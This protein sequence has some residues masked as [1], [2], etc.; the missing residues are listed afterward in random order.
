VPVER[1]T[2]Y[3]ER[4]RIAPEE[5]P[6]GPQLGPRADGTPLLQATTDTKREPSTAD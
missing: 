5:S 6:F 1:S 3:T 4:R 2:D